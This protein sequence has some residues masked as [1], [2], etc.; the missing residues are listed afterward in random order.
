P[1]TPRTLRHALD[2]PTRTPLHRPRRNQPRPHTPRTPNQRHLPRPPKPTSPLTPGRCHARRD[3]R[4]TMRVAGVVRLRRE[5]G[6]STSLARQ[7][8]VIKKWADLGDHEIPGWANARLTVFAGR[9][10]HL[11]YGPGVTVPLRTARP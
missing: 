5:T 9:D 10:T 8:E 6:E 1:T 2:H 4:A 7:R 11:P 3:D